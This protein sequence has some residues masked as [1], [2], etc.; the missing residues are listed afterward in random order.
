MHYEAGDWLVSN[1]EDESD[2]YA[3]RAATFAILYEPDPVA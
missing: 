1:G 3:I 2:A